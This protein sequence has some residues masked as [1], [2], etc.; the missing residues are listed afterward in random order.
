M[1]VHQP[2]LLNLFSNISSWHFCCFPYFVSLILKNY[3]LS[4][5]EHGLDH[6]WVKWKCS[7]YVSELYE[8]LVLLVNFFLLK[9]TSSKTT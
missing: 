8:H 4:N 6:R 2:R 5:K 7:Q 3:S 9:I 1:T